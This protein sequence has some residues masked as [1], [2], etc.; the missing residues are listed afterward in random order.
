MHIY[1]YICTH[2]EDDR[3]I[4]KRIKYSYDTQREIF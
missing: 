2:I 1:K 3:N 4:S